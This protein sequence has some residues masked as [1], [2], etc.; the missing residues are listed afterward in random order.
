M[1]A[2]AIAITAVFVTHPRDENGY[3][4]YVAKYGDYNGRKLADPPPSE[5]LIKAGDRACNWLQRRTPA[6]WRTDPNHRINSLYLSY[7]A[8]MSRADRNLP[9]TM[10]PGAWEYLC[11]G[12]KALIRPHDVFG[13]ASHD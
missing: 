5:V 13:R 12:T 9:K 6:L 11:P 10:L 7:L 4:N 1:L 2:F 8:H 3:L